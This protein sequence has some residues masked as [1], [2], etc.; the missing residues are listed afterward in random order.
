M[1]AKLNVGKQKAKQEIDLIWQQRESL[2]TAVNFAGYSYDQDVRFCCGA[3][4]PGA[5]SAG[6]TARIGVRI[7]FRR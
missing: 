1:R 4:G 2:A 6:S 3:S 5:R 7:R